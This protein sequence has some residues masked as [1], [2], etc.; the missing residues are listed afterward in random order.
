M[1]AKV[2]VVGT[3][4]ADKAGLDPRDYLFDMKAGQHWRTT[5]LVPDSADD[6]S[7][8]Q[9]IETIAYTE[10][11]RAVLTVPPG[12]D[13]TLYIS[14]GIEYSVDR[15][16]V[17][18]QAGQVQQVTSVLKREV[19]TSGYISADFHL[20]AKPSL[21][22]ALPLD[23]RV[24]SVVGEGV[25]VLVSTDHNY[26]TDYAPTI[27]DL[28]LQDWATSMVGLELT[29]LESG[30]FNGYP[31]KRDPG[32]ITKGAFEWSLRPPDDIFDMIRSMGS[33]SPEE[34]IVQVNHPRDSILGYFSQY[35][36]D[37]LTAGLPVPPDCTLP[38][39]DV[40]GCV[41]PP[42]GPAFRTAEG[43]STF[44][45][46]FDAIEV[47]N[48]SV[49]GQLHH[50]RMPDSLEGIDVPQ[51]FRDNAPDPGTILCDGDTLAY[52][53]VADDWF[54]LLNLGY[55]HI[56][57]GTSDSHDA[58]DHPGAGRTFV[59]V[60]DDHPRRVS[61]KTIV[62]GLKGHRA[63]MTS[64]PFV[65]FTV[66]D[67]P[68]G[69][70]V[71]AEGGQVKIDIMCRASWIHVDTGIIWANGQALF[72]PDRKQSILNVAYDDFAENT[73]IAVEVRGPNQCSPSPTVI[74]HRS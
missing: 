11:G 34:T 33:L 7:T 38:L 44:S 13:W 32:A 25:E 31:L 43:E 62:A 66:N 67:A 19:D 14:R 51:D 50:Q 2:T 23:E 55:R 42:N 61:E 10:D 4:P 3:T 41:L 69:S 6:A 53:G 74:S 8:R 63:I 22:S 46:N 72:E 15:V 58:E 37:P 57:T 45:Y 73:W 70:D 29:P 54:N 64:G 60:G 9:F 1:P 48:G 59:W 35:N 26:V 68:I 49:T 47:L 21:D 71:S 56:G 18:V 16:D 28:A 17:N 36:L 40:S 39:S 65:E 20:H 27:S 24:L 30:H 12:K 52:A 5:D